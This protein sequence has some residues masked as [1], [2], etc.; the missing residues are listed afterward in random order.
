ML[1]AVATAGEDGWGVTLC[2]VARGL[3][4][5]LGLGVPCAGVALNAYSLAGCAPAAAGVPVAY[6]LLCGIRTPAC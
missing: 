6:V 2:V 3:V 5:V 1:L 4:G